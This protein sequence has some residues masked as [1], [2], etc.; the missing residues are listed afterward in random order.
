MILKG[1][2]RANCADL[3]T[4][5]MNGYDNERVELGEVRGTIAD[6][7]HGAFAEIEAIASGTRAQKPLFS[8][9]V[10]PYEALTREQYFEAIDAIESRLGL[11]GQPRAVVF[12]EK[13][14]REHCH[15]VWSRIDG[16]QMKAISDSFYKSRLCDMAVALAEQFGHELPEGLKRWKEK[17]RRFE[18]KLEPSLAETANAKKTGISAAERREEITSAY[19]QADSATAFVNALEEKGY[20]LARGDIRAFVIVDKFGDVHSLSRYVKGVRAKEINA[21]LSALDID[22]MPNVEQAKD[23][24][25]ARLAAQEERLRKQQDVQ[26]D[27]QHDDDHHRDRDDRAE[28]RHEDDDRYRRSID[29]KR[30][31]MERRQAARELDLALAEQEL[32]TRH[33]QEKLSLDAAQ[34]AESGSLLF[35]MR[36][37]VASLIEKTPA[38][39][40]VL[41]HIT[42]RTGLDPHERHRLEQQALARRHGRER[43]AMDGRKQAA[44][45]IA[46]REEA[47]LQCDLKREALRRMLRQE[48][49]R[50]SAKS[51]RLGI[52]EAELL[53]TDPRLLEEGG[54]SGEFD[55]AVCDVHGQNGEG[56]EEDRGGG[57]SRVAA[58]S[59]V[60]RKKRRSMAAAKA[61]ATGIVVMIDG[62]DDCARAQSIA[63]PI[64][65]QNSAEQATA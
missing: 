8:L 33:Q 6:D 24:A 58:G 16:V 26:H 1:S 27:H 52:A 30:A 2:C 57:L 21:R 15:V 11:T 46:N 32:L 23:Q 35:R 48:R 39:R 38:L 7:L 54:L 28:D 42:S 62:A 29:E 45:K 19:V 14:G 12:H 55:A 49:L 63:D 10:N 56:E 17:N 20:V 40:S 47:S 53:R 41:G 22:G 25:R 64:R 34:K 18:E 51:E 60:R 43:R 9:S 5:L 50:A 44:A 37:S 61:A 3:A 13:D 31:A 36:A 65:L 4:H 59:S